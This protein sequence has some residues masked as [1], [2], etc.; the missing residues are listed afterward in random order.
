MLLGL[1]WH[2]LHSA[3]QKLESLIL[4][5]ALQGKT[6][7]AAMKQV[8]SPKKQLAASVDSV[9]T[10]NSLISKAARE[11][12]QEQYNTA[13]QLLNEADRLQPED[14]ATL[15]LRGQVKGKQQDY[16]GA[17][18][19]LQGRADSFHTL[20]HRAAL[21]RALGDKD[22][23]FADV[24]AADVLMPGSAAVWCSYFEDYVKRL[25]A[26]HGAD[27][28][29]RDITTGKAVMAA[30]RAHMSNAPQVMLVVINILATYKF[31]MCSC[32]S[33]A[34]A[35]WSC[36]HVWSLSCASLLVYLIKTCKAVQHIYSK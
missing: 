5:H 13:L 28:G 24:L 19:D 9:N 4:Q 27:I 36:S 3:L 14:Y 6:S 18:Q 33:K 26:E 15:Q 2:A 32:N 35:G 12:R 17:V 1:P 30:L 25:E 16:I 23:S 11:Y 8:A 29:G 10:A 22:K 20:S 7:D 21:H 31:D 34:H